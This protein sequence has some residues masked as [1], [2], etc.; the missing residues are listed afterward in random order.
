[1]KLLTGN[2]V[3]ALLVDYVIKMNKAQIDK[4]STVVKTVVTSELGAAI[5]KANGCRVVETL[6]GF[7]FIGEQM[8][9][10]EKTGYKFVIGYEE[11]YGYLVGMHARDK[12]AVVS[13]MLICEMACYYKNQ[14]K[15]LV[16]VMEDIY[17]EY[18]YYLDKLDNFTLKGIDGLEKIGAIMKEMRENGKALLSDVITVYDY[19]KGIDDLPKSDVLKFIFEDG[20]WI[21]IR[22]SGTEPKIKIYYSIR[23]ESKDEAT[24]VLEARRA[25]IARVIDA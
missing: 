14:G 16:D 11:S 8:C 24:K 13:S 20:S 23:G 4:T 17:A 7:K 25:V 22:P 19:S 3:G 5:A 2:Q 10:Y 9:I 12:D 15:T 6:T 21:A 1:M 18:G